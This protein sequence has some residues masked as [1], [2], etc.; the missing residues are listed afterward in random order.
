MLWLSQTLNIPLQQNGE[1]VFFTINNLPDKT[2]SYPVTI[3]PAADK[4]DVGFRGSSG[5]TLFYS[6][7]VNGLSATLSGTVTVTTD[8]PTSVAASFTIDWKSDDNYK[9]EYLMAGT[10]SIDRTPTLPDLSGVFTTQPPAKIS[11]GA[12]ITPGLTIS[13]SGT[14]AKGTETTNYYLSKTKDL[15]GGPS[16][17]GT[18]VS[19][20]ID[21]Q[22]GGSASENPTFNIPDNTQP[23]T[24]YLIANVNADG[25]IPEGNAG[26]NLAFSGPTQIGFLPNLSAEYTGTLPD[27][28]SPGDLLTPTLTL[29]DSGGEA[30][31]TESTDYF[32]STAPYSP[33]MRPRFSPA[34]RSR[35]TCWMAPS[36]P[37]PRTLR[38]RDIQSGT[39][40]LIA[41]INADGSIRESDAA[42][43]TNNIAV[44][45]AIEIHPKIVNV[46]THGFDPSIT[47]WLGSNPAGFLQQFQDLATKLKTTL[48]TGTALNGQVDS[49]VANWDSTSGFAPAL[50]GVVASV[51]D[52]NPLRRFSMTASLH[53]R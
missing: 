5:A 37:S 41:K 39:Y 10:F 53:S 47:A 26:N 16:Q 3:D 30:K 8:T 44:S 25:A 6:S 34:F 32:L 7:D 15:S 46:I 49:Y 28:A 27:H 38:S 22:A 52:S 50:A 11:R 51:L 20:L 35:S 24:Y 19:E 13:N 2:G 23:G 4:V 43:D 31:G 18:P 12:S 33:R 36:P 9:F 45:G 17:L 48:T 40:Y 14:E 1:D 21:L 42:P 29:S